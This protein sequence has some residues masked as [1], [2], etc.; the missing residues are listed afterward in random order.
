MRGASS[1]N[2]R[3]EFLTCAPSANLFVDDELSQV[4]AIPTTGFFCVFVCFYISFCE[5]IVVLLV[6]HFLIHLHPFG[7]YDYLF[8]NKFSLNLCRETAVDLLYAMKTG[9]GFS[10]EL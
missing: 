2:I 8:L 7:F 4:Y 1:E 3:L 9:D 5:T 10:A 6:F